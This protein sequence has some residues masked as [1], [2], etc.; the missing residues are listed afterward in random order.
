M[1]TINLFYFVKGLNG[2]RIL[3]ISVIRFGTKLVE[4]KHQERRIRTLTHIELS[5]VQLK[6]HIS[7][8]VPI[9]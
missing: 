5:A 4:T 2:L 6:G 1:Q 7:A 9:G 3:E 8:K